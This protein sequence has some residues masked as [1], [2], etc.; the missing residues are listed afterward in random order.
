MRNNARQGFSQ[1]LAAEFHRTMLRPQVL[2]VAM[3]FIIFSVGMFVFVTTMLQLSAARYGDVDMMAE[4]SHFLGFGAPLAISSFCCGTY[5]AAFTAGD[6]NDGTVMSSLALAPKRLPLFF[7]RMTPWV[8]LCTACSFISFVV[9]FFLALPT[10]DDIGMAIAQLFLSTASSAA[11]CVMAFCCATATKKGSFSICLFLTLQLVAPWGFNALI[12][13]GPEFLQAAASALDITMPGTA[14][15]LVVQ[16]IQPSEGLVMT[17]IY[18]G[19][20]STVLWTIAFPAFAYI[21]FRDRATL[22]I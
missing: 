17:H 19:C 4:S 14:F 21:L 12:D 18:A 16:I 15:P 5:C 1:M 20:V 6:Y 9:V 8:A 10:I 7:A 2:V 22:G 11:T 13:F 3:V